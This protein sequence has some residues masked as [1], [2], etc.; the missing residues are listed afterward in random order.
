VDTINNLFQYC[1]EN[2]RICPMPIF[3]NEL[4]NKLKNKKYKEP[5]VPL[6]L[7]AWYEP[8]LLK[9]LRFF[10]HLEWAKKQGQLEEIS[11]YVKNL[12]EEN[13]YHLGE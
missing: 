1:K 12:K 13:W 7:A 11:D 6:I 4:Y 9:Q 8:A 5:A 10:E 2:D 3:W